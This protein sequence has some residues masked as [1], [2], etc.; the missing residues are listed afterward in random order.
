MVRM[1]PKPMLEG[2]LPTGK[3]VWPEEVSK[4]RAIR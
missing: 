3:V 4:D 1:N 2:V